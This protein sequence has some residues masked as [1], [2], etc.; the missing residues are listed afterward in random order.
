MRDVVATL[1]NMAPSDQGE[2]AV[3]FASL[4]SLQST[5][6]T[7]LMDDEEIAKAREQHQSSSK[8][9]A[10]FLSH[11]KEACAA[12]ARLVKQNYEDL[13]GVECFLG[14]FHAAAFIASL[15]LACSNNANWRH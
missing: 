9:F 6:G 11:H 5:G 14:A 4:Q 13:L 1:V 12:E 8:S 3:E 7:F 2:I 15:S 10:V